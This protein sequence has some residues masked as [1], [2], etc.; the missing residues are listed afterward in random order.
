L[1]FGAFRSGQF[2]VWMTRSSGFGTSQTS[3]TPISQ[4]LAS[5]ARSY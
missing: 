2:I 1:Y 4:R 5:P 3:L